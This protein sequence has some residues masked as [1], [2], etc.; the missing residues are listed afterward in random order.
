MPAARSRAWPSPATSGLGSSSADTTRAIP[1]AM[2]ASAQGGDLPWCEQGSSVTYSVAPRPASPARRNAST[3]AWGRP[4]G[5][6]QPRPTMTPSLTITAPTAGFGQVRPSPRRPSDSASAM[7]R[8]SSFCVT[9]ASHDKF[10]SMNVAL[11]RAM[12]VDEYLAWSDSQSERQRT[13]LINGQI[14]VALRQAVAAANLPCEVMTDGVAVRIDEHTAYEPD[15]L[16]RCGSELPGEMMIVPDPMIVVEVLSPTT[17]HSDTSAKL[18]GY[19]KVPS[20]VHYLV[21]DPDDRTVTHYTRDG[22]A[23]L[24]NNGSLRLDPPG[25]DLTVEDLFGLA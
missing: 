15:A 8:L 14:Y 7:K 10:H 23:A 24:L 9:A 17:A 21:V 13:E 5:W 11:R 19:F 12:T 1:A 6:V 4:P 18:I 25:I 2:T 22:T 16:V 3:S 20:V